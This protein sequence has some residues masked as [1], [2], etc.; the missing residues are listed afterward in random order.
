MVDGQLRTEFNH[1]DDYLPEIPNEDSTQF[2]IAGLFWITTSCCF[3]IAGISANKPIL[4]MIGLGLLALMLACWLIPNQIHK[5]Q[6]RAND[7]GTK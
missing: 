4:Y 1:A 7:A 3:S 5:W 6:R 2:S